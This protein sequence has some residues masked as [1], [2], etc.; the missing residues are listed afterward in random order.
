MDCRAS[1]DT[2]VLPALDPDLTE[3]YLFSSP[4]ISVREMQT[5]LQRR[6]FRY[7]TFADTPGILEVLFPQEERVTDS[8]MRTAMEQGL[9]QPGLDETRAGRW[10]SFP[11]QTM[12]TDTTCQAFVAFANALCG[13]IFEKE[14]LRPRLTWVNLYMPHANL[15]PIEADHRPQII[16]SAA[17]NPADRSALRWWHN[18]VV[19]VEVVQRHKVERA[20]I[21]FVRRAAQIFRGQANRRFLF[22]L[23]VAG[24]FFQVW[25]VDRSG[26]MMSEYINIHESPKDVIRLMS[27]FCLK[28]DHQL[29]WDLTLRPSTLRSLHPFR[30]LWECSMSTGDGQEEEFVLYHEIYLCHDEI[31]HG[32]ATRVWK[33]WR[34]VDICKPIQERKIYVIKDAWVREDVRLEGETFNLVGPSDGLVRLESYRIIQQIPGQDDET[35]YMSQG[36]KIE[37]AKVNM[38]EILQQAQAQPD[39]DDAFPQMGTIDFGDTGWLLDI[40]RYYVDHGMRRPLNFRHSRALLAD[41]GW[42]LRRFTSLKELLGGLHDA[43]RGPSQGM[44]T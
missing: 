29:G 40:D 30:P 2:V 9:Y 38:Q 3:L 12:S 18:A 16:A 37:G 15:S 42:S 17:H 39:S 10:A 4:P 32:R 35:D 44:S 20:V 8:I 21:N 28:S 36:L 14:H 43:I 11:A 23:I 26:S 27:G 5:M 13:M 25:M 22:G 24:P 41:Y 34:K 19:H 33:A 1:H 31:L 6:S 7:P